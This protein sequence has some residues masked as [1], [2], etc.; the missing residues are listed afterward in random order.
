MAQGTLPK[1]RRYI[2]RLKLILSFFVFICEMLLRR[3]AVKGA[4]SAPGL[5][6]F[7]VELVYNTLLKLIFIRFI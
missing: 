1:K 6:I 5:T 2:I 3:S 4:E 7:K